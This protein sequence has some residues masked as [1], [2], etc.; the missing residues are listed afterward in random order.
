MLAITRYSLSLKIAVLATLISG[1][2]RL[3][4]SMTVRETAVKR[5]SIKVADSTAVKRTLKVCNSICLF[6]HTS[7]TQNNKLLLFGVLTSNVELVHKALAR[8]PR[9]SLASVRVER[10]ETIHRELGCIDCEVPLVMVNQKVIDIAEHI[11]KARVSRASY[12]I[13]KDLELAER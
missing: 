11:A 1:S 4:Y 12:A 10:F 3:S 2:F 13:L 5:A 9:H 6:E 7:D 8:H